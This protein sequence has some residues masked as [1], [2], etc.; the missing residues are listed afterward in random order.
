[1]P[2]ATTWPY[3]CVMSP[4]S[5]WADRGPVTNLQLRWDLLPLKR[6]RAVLKDQ[7]FSPSAL[8]ISVPQWGCKG[9]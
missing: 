1:M 9:S 3:G 5:G 4:S 2:A 8:R 6:L 7:G